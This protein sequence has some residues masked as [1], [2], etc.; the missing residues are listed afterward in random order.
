[1]V[2]DEY[3]LYRQKMTPDWKTPKTNQI[4]EGSSKTATQEVKTR[5]KL[6]SLRYE[7]S[8][9]FFLVFFGISELFAVWP[10]PNQVQRE[11]MK[12]AREERM[13]QTR[14]WRGGVTGDDREGGQK[15]AG[16]IWR[17]PQ[18]SKAMVSGMVGCVRV[19]YARVILKTGEGRVL[20]R[21]V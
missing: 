7:M 6:V 20:S 5:K 15:E 1:M 8:T 13:R 19:K 2:T 12:V 10:E 9:V 4:R 11:G 16:H 18:S 17:A 21:N 14:K 3:I